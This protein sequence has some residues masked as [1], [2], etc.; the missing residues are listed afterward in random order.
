MDATRDGTRGDGTGGWGPVAA[1]FALAYALA[2]AWWLPLA[3]S[4]AS[5]R[6]GDAWPTHLPGLAA[7]L[8]AAAVVLAVVE[9]R[10]GLRRWAGAFGRLPRGRAAIVVACAPLAVL[11]VTLIV[12]AALGDVEAAGRYSGAAAGLGWVVL[13]VTFNAFGEEAG[14]RGFALPRLQDR[15]GPLR[16]SLMLAVLWA[17]WHAPLFVVLDSYAGFGPLTLLGF[18]VG[19]GAG[20][21]VLTSVY[22]LSGG[23]ILAA[24]VWHAGYNL[25][26]ATDAAGD[27]TA[28]AVTALV[29]T[30]AVALIR[31]DRAGL[32]GLGPNGPG[33]AARRRPRLNACGS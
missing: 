14:W 33:R 4:G 30:W 17:G 2:W 25:A 8:V 13:A 20:S 16:A 18:L 3:A 22:N 6:R 26:V 19:I 11:L 10:R 28:V 24:A 21:V 27:A 29:V 1:F 15:L 23:S 32:P 12:A 31:R 5:V 7:P 9:G